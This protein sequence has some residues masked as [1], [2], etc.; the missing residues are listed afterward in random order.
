MLAWG[1]GDAIAGRWSPSVLTITHLLTLGFM[2]MVMIGALFQVFP[3]VMGIGIP[4]GRT[5]AGLVH[6]AFSL[7]TVLLAAGL[8]P[9]SWPWVMP[10]A[11]SLLAG[12][13]LLL[14]VSLAIGLV[15]ARGNASI[16]LAVGAA[17]M[18]LLVTVVLGLLLGAGYGE[19]VGPGLDRRWTD[20]HAVW[21]LLGWAGL[22]VVGLAYEV[23]PMFQ[24][25][26][27]YPG[28]MR[29]GLSAALLAALGLWS[30]PLVAL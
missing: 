12:A 17:L 25:T 16:H 24:A 23:V 20:L 11:L 10:V 6:V 13:F 3:V 27:A 9:V 28:W 15:V 22:L 4:G 29:N 30:L 1:G 8:I 5:V 21:G 7:G 26:P 14:L 19:G 2:A 18:A